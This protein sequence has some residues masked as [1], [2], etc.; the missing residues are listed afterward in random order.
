MNMPI[1]EIKTIEYITY[2][3]QEKDKQKRE[4]EALEDAV[5]EIT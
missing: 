2:K 5:E 3:N 1:D 4:A